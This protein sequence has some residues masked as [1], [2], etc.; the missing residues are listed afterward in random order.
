MRICQV[1]HLTS[2][3][4]K[5]IQHQILFLY[6]AYG[7]SPP[8]NNHRLHDNTTSDIIVICDYAKSCTLQP[9]SA[10]RYS[11]TTHDSVAIREC[12]KS[13]TSHSSSARK[14]NVTAYY[15]KTRICQ[16]PSAYSHL[17]Q[18]TTTAKYAN[19]LNHSTLQQS[20]V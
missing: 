4:C 8:P 3:V 16:V 13:P 6:Y 5:I 2:I 11:C 7:P 12:T 18:Y 19:L 15:C 10:I 1:L 9:F 20:S 14:C 17:L